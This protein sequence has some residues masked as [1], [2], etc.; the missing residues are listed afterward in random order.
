MHDFQSLR[1]VQISEFSKNQWFS[2]SHN[3]KTTWPTPKI[4][5]PIKSWDKKL[6][7]QTGQST[8]GLQTWKQQPVEN[9]GL[10]FSWPFFTSTSMLEI[11]L[12][13]SLEA[14]F[15]VSN[16]ASLKVKVQVAIFGQMFIALLFVLLSRLKWQKKLV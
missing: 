14:Y 9:G 3:S 15:T 7:F 8:L 4:R 1:S 12:T 16:L 6:S 5:V 13:H 10:M 2:M 11:S